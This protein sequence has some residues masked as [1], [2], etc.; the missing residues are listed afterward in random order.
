VS[1]NV[2]IY[3]AFC[4]FARSWRTYSVRERERKIKI[5][6]TIVYIRRVYYITLLALLR[7]NVNP[8]VS[9]FLLEFISFR[10]HRS[11]QLDFCP[12]NDFHPQKKRKNTTRSENLRK[13]YVN[14]IY[15][16]YPRIL[17]FTFRSKI[18]NTN[19]FL[20]M[21]V[22]QKVTISEK[23]DGRLKARLLM[24]F[25]PGKIL[26]ERDIR[27]SA[28]VHNDQVACRRIDIYFHVQ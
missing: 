6:S 1:Q 27:R 17:L 16:L 24:K 5:K 3:L 2:Y 28:S 18:C 4:L 15:Q 25:R 21:T 14:T 26:L 11:G 22:R 10:M 7:L 19:C 23:F 9:F 20:I 12:L 13:V 8:W